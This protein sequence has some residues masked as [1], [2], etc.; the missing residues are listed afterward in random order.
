MISRLIPALL[1]LPLVSG[2][3]ADAKTILVTPNVI[4]TD[5]YITC[6]VTNLDTKAVKVVVDL[7]NSSATPLSTIG[8]TCNSS[9]L[10]SG[11]TCYTTVNSTIG[12]TSNAFCRFEVSS[13]KVKASLQLRDPDRGTTLLVVPAAKP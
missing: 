2:T 1:T 9:L 6:T 7:Y 10:G 12:I 8:D 4:G 3:T 11:Q 13:A 5:K